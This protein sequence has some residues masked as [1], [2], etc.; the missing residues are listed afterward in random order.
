M[1]G[2]WSRS[3]K[4]VLEHKGKKIFDLKLPEI[5]LHPIFGLVV[6]PGR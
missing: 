2:S 3:V 4:V 1:A 5:S 6:C